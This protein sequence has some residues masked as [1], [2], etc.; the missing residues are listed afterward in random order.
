MSSKLEQRIMA[1]YQQITVGGKLTV[2]SI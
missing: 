1:A 2:V